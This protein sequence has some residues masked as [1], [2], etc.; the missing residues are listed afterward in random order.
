MDLFPGLNSQVRRTVETWCDALTRHL[1]GGRWSWMAATPKPFVHASRT[2]TKLEKPLGL[3]RCASR[4]H[5]FLPA[6]CWLSKDSK[7]VRLEN[8]WHV[9]WMSNDC[10]GFLAEP[11]LLPVTANLP[12]PQ[13]LRTR[14]KHNFAVPS[15]RFGA[16]RGQTH[17]KLQVMVWK[18]FGSFGWN[19]HHENQHFI[20]MRLVHFF[21]RSRKL[22][23][24]TCEDICSKNGSD[25]GEFNGL[26]VA[27]SEACGT[28]ICKSYTSCWFQTCFCFHPRTWGNDSHFDLSIFF[29]WVVQPSTFV[30]VW[31]DEYLFL[32]NGTP[33]KQGG[34]ILLHGNFLSAPLKNATVSPGNTASWTD[35][36]SNHQLILH[37]WGTLLKTNLKICLPLQK[38]LV[39]TSCSIYLT[40]PEGNSMVVSTRFQEYESKLDHFPKISG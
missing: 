15:Y 6:F 14:A 19:F 39:T 25:F 36:M 20:G 1:A 12:W 34:Y 11:V 9:G 30:Y 28:H 37:H 31:Q 17:R 18:I 26:E 8:A 10:K 21:E 29:R 23:L 13:V 4:Y 35:W 7:D 38:K 27:S 33:K 16:G 22:N 3:W 24:S 32:L 40:L 2:T 5:D